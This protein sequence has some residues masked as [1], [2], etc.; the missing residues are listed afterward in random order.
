MTGPSTWSPSSA[1]AT[2]CGFTSGPVLR[3][4]W[5]KADGLN[6]PETIA[7]WETVMQAFKVEERRRGALL[8]SM[9][10]L[11][12]VFVQAFEVT[13]AFYPD[14]KVIKFGPMEPGFKAYLTQ[15][16]AWYQKG[17]IDKNFMTV[18]RKYQDAVMTNNKAAQATA[19]SAPRS[20][21]TSSRARRPTPAT[22]WWPRP[23]RS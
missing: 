23:S 6:P 14:E 5:L 18:D 15:L 13:Q 8:G 2:S 7:E 11:Q 3:A 21:P 12:R 4:D 1:A 19:R 20:A 22:T 10:H 9:D 17:L 16:A